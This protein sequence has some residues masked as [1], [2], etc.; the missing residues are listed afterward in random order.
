MWWRESIEETKRHCGMCFPSKD[1]IKQ[2]WIAKAGLLNSC[3]QSLETSG[4]S[5]K[6]SHCIVH[7]LDRIVVQQEGSLKPNTLLVKNQIPN[8]S[9]AH[10]HAE[11]GRQQPSFRTWHT[12]S[13]L[14][15]L[16]LRTSDRRLTCS[17]LESKVNSTGYLKF[18]F[19]SFSSIFFQSH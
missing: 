4:M 3:L 5:L 19:S 12:A 18:Y 8:C 15:D 11:E 10:C 16:Y 14:L 17:L 7:R 13:C 6:L 1:I 2:N 9:D